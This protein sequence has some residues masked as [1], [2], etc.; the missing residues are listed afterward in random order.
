MT[1]TQQA[2]TIYNE[3]DTDRSVIGTDDEFIV[4]S[5]YVPGDL[6]DVP[7][8]GSDEPFLTIEMI[9]QIPGLLPGLAEQLR[10]HWAILGE[11]ATQED[12]DHARGLSDAA[13]A[14]QWAL[15][16]ASAG[17]EGL[18]FE[19]LLDDFEYLRPALDEVLQA[20]FPGLI[21]GCGGPLPE[22]NV[23]IPRTELASGIGVEAA[24]GRL[25]AAVPAWGNFLD[26]IAPTRQFHSTEW[27]ADEFSGIPA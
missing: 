9:N 8:D 26:W 12:A 25:V 19:V 3:F 14:E 23:R 13:L 2:V 1:T 24:H 22:A 4:Y 6:L 5:E 27:S 15:A 20:R 17:E 18:P 7:S 16:F 21:W 10:T 11:Y